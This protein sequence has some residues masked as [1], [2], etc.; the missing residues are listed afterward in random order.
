MLMFFAS[1]PLAE[2]GQ[3]TGCMLMTKNWVKTSLMRSSG[4]GTGTRR[5]V[6]R[7]AGTVSTRCV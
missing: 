6:R 5:P 3:K 4:R 7:A 1:S 2:S